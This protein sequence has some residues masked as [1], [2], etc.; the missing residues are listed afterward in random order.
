MADTWSHLSVSQAF[1]LQSALDPSLFIRSPPE[2]L[3]D[4]TVLVKMQQGDSSL[5]EVRIQTDGTPRMHCGCLG[6]FP[7]VQLCSHACWLLLWFGNNPDIRMFC[8]PPTLRDAIRTA[9]QTL[10]TE[11]AWHERNSRSNGSWTGLGETPR[12]NW[13]TTVDSTCVS[14]NDDCPICLVACGTMASVLCAACSRAFHQA[15]AERWGNGCPM[16]RYLGR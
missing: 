3:E 2:L 4:G 14:A 8:H 5:G 12:Q 15:C 9:G 6:M 7:D 13:W 16:C 10:M 11:G 1:E